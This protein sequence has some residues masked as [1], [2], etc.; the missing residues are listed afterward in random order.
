MSGEELVNP[1][2][3]ELAHITLRVWSNAQRMREEAYRADRAIDERHYTSGALEGQIRTFARYIID[4]TDEAER[5]RAVA[6]AA[7]HLMD[8]SGEADATDDNGAPFYEHFGVDHQRLSDALDALEATG[9]DA[10][11]EVAS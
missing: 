11:P 10:H 5:Y 8:D 6:H 1:P 9:W 2:R 3:E 4:L 7:W